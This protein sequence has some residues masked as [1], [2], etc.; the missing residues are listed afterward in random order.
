M[1]EINDIECRI[2]FE[3]D[4]DIPGDYL[5]SP[6]R[7]NG[8]SKYVHKSCLDKWRM[9]NRQGEAWR[10][11]MECH[12]PYEFTNSFSL[13]STTL[14]TY[15]SLISIYLLQYV[16]GLFFSFV[17]WI[18]D[19]YND[20]ESIRLLNYNIT[21]PEPSLLTFVKND[22]AAPQIY[23]I[24]LYMFIQNIIVY[25]YF[26]YIMIFNIK[27]KSFYISKIY[28]TFLGT[29]LLSMQFIIYYYLF[30]F[31]NSPLLFLNFSTFSVIINPLYYYRLVQKHNLIIREMNQTNQVEIVSYTYNPV[32]NRILDESSGETK[33]SNYVVQVE[34]E[35]NETMDEKN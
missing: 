20:Y 12:T 13:E 11:C 33:V 16:C 22:N 34:I 31:N 29:L 3:K 35:L 14:L 15:N 30:A 32:Y 18:V 6:C 19:A 17:I 4:T 24:S 23:Y 10:K 8:T 28:K 25:L 27:R 1:S 26:C 5:I 7:C 21:L 9:T 2:C